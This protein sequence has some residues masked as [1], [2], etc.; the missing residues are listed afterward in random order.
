MAIVFLKGRKQLEGL[1]DDLPIKYEAR[2]TSEFHHK[3]SDS[4]VTLA[5]LAYEVTSMPTKPQMKMVNGAIKIWAIN[6]LYG[7]FA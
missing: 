7:F 3:I 1:P 2:S 4:Y 5:K 6:G